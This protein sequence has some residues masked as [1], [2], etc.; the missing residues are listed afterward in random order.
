MTH[1]S[2]SGLQSL[3]DAFVQVSFHDDC[4]AHASADK[5]YDDWVKQGMEETGYN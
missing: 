2:K 5:L 3:E 4:E 1:T